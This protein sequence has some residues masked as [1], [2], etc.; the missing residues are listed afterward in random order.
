MILYKLQKIA[1][2]CQELN[3]LSSNVRDED[4]KSMTLQELEAFQSELKNFSSFRLLF[5]KIDKA[6]EEKKNEE[7]IKLS[8]K[9]HYPAIQKI[10]W[11]TDA[12]KANL[13][14]YLANLGF[15]SYLYKESSAFRSLTEGWA[16]ETKEQVLQFLVDSNILEHLYRLAVCHDT[17]LIT[18]KQAD[19]YLGYFDMKK[20][21]NKLKKQE[22]DML[23]RL[24]NSLTFSFSCVY[25]DSEVD[26]GESHIQNAVNNPSC[27]VYKIIKESAKC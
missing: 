25:C 11:L 9:Y 17:E 26:I 21:L 1:R 6:I 16:K 8:K 24:E 5:E 23:Q 4:F 10:N 20:R 2:K 19:D 13:D 7:N 15:N 14:C 18:G 3:S 27:H 22:R 12:D